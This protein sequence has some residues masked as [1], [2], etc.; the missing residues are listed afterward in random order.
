MTTTSNALTLKETDDQGTDYEL[1]PDFSSC[2]VEVDTVSVW[3][4]RAGDSVIV[5]LCRTGEEST[6]TLDTAE[7]KL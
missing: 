7:A 3:I 1:D 4:R 2:W 5:E 6:S